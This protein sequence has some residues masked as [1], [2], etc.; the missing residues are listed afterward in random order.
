MF[1]AHSFSEFALML[2]G[3][4]AIGVGWST[5]RWLVAKVLK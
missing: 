1:A 4:F 2:A 5:G 3:L